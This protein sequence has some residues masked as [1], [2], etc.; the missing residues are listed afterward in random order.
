MCFKAQAMHLCDYEEQVPAP[1]PIPN[2]QDSGEKWLQRRLRGLTENDEAN[3][4]AG[5][6]ALQSGKR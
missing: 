1:V 4:S 6:A 3:A 5:Y 2:K